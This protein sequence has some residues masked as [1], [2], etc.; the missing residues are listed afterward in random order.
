MNSKPSVGQISIHKLSRQQNPRCLLVSRCLY[1]RVGIQKEWSLVDGGG[2][3]KRPRNNH[4]NT[5]NMV[6]TPP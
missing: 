2:E 6:P 5:K 4:W 1:K 3:K